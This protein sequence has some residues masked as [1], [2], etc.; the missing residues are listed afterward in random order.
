MTHRIASWAVWL[1]GC[2]EKDTDDL[3]PRNRTTKAQQGLKMTTPLITNP[4]GWSK[5]ARLLKWICDRLAVADPH[6]TTAQML[7]RQSTL[8]LPPQQRP[9]TQTKSCAAASDAMRPAWR[10]LLPLAVL[11]WHLSARAAA[12]QQ[13][14]HNPLERINVG[15]TSVQGDNQIK[16]AVS[17]TKLT[18][19]KGELVEVRRP[20]VGLTE[21]CTALPLLLLTAS[22]TRTCR[23]PGTAC[24]TLRTQTGSA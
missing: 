6:K 1:Y 7:E 15:A 20:W 4:A 19:R 14:T 13:D 24:S 23:S 2:G 10:T 18:K 12:R 5:A 21:P 3:E 22:P 9:Y 17:T 16:L 11:C 8:C